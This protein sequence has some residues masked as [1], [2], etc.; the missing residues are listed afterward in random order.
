[1]SLPKLPYPDFEYTQEETLEYG[2]QCWNAAIESAQGRLGYNGD[3][4]EILEDLLITADTVS[5]NE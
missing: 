1:M 4:T 2:R 5:T 3:D